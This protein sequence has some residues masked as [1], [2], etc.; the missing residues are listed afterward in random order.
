V[1]DSVTAVATPPKVS[2]LAFQLCNTVPEMA[3]VASFAVV[4]PEVMVSSGAL[5]F[6]C[7]PR[8]PLAAAVSTVPSMSSAFIAAGVT[9]ILN[10]PA[11]AGSDTVPVPAVVAMALKYEDAL[12]IVYAE[13]FCA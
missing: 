11:S 10:V 1:F 6:T 13:S 5:T 12:L 3:S 4:A 8:P 7:A 9:D 2:E